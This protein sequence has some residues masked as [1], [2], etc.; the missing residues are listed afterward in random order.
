MPKYGIHQIVLN[1]TIQKLE[2]AGADALAGVMRDHPTAAMLGAIGPDLFFWAPDY[3]LGEALHTFYSIYSQTR[4]IYDTIVK[5]IHDA[6]EEIK[7]AGQ[8]L[9]PRTAALIEALIAEIQ[10]LSATFRNTLMSGLFVG[11]IDGVDGMADA[12]NTPSVVGEFFKL[13]SPPLQPVPNSLPDLLPNSREDEWYWFDMLHYRKTGEFARELINRVPRGNTAT[14]VER[15]MAYAFGYLSHVATDLVGHAYVNQVVGGP[16]RLQVHRHVTVENFM[17]TWAF[18]A[19]YGESVNATLMERLGFQP[20]LAPSELEAWVRENADL[21]NL[22]FEA[23]QD[24]GVYNNQGAPHPELLA[25]DQLDEALVNFYNVLDLMKQSSTQRPEEPFEGVLDILEDLFSDLFEP[26]PNTPPP[27]AVDLDQWAQWLMAFIDY[28]F[29]TLQDLFDALSAL[30]VAALA[31]VAMAIMYGIQLVLYEFYQ[32]IRW[33]LVRFG[34]VYPEPGDLN[35]PLGGSLIR[36][37]QCEIEGCVPG[38]DL[39]PYPRRQDPAVTAPWAQLAC[40]SSTMVEQIPTSPNFD[41]TSSPDGSPASFIREE[42]F[43]IDVLREYANAGLGQIADLWRSCA[44]IGNATDLAAWMIQAA[45]G[46]PNADRKLAFTNWNLDAD[47]GY[48][49]RTWEGRILVSELDG[50]DRVDIESQTYGSV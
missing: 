15:R 38:T 12:L 49:F 40:S 47:R 42:P 6:E 35:D 3:E 14:R 36:P 21:L 2:D 50:V 17:D 10:Q 8:Q 16:Y 46:P 27:T 1:D 20:G 19:W 41:E 24:P 30:G 45:A 9:T 26:P 13:F 34:F 33:S 39:W 23:M 4:E 37:G 18:D 22:L 11:V 7:Q 29:E 28:T 5:P 43:S 44:R 31:T 25:R 48:G 32:A